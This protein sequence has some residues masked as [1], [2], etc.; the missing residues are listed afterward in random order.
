MYSRYQEKIINDVQTNLEEMGTQPILFIG[1][2][3]SK[4]YFGAPNWKELLHLLKEGGPII[5]H[6]PAYYLQDG[7]S[8]AEIG[9]IYTEQYREW[10]WSN[11][12]L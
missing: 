11:Q 12:H 8:L 10:A 7:K 1:S 2:G 5:P 6:S 3:L 4:R 9:S